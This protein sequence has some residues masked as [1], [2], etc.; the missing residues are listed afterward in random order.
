MYTYTHTILGNSKF[1]LL[2]LLPFPCNPLFSFP[3]PSPLP[4]RPSFPNKM[5]QH[6]SI[7]GRRLLSGAYPTLSFCGFS[8]GSRDLN[9]PPPPF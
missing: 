5:N 3:S 4:E 6:S 2:F 8:F 7:L 1:L 9:L